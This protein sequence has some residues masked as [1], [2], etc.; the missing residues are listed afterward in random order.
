[1]LTRA[2]DHIRIELFAEQAAA[3][4]FD[5]F[6]L[7]GRDIDRIGFN[8]LRL[9]WQSVGS[10][11]CESSGSSLRSRTIAREDRSTRAHMVPCQLGRMPPF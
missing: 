2:F 8:S 5:E 9:A 7:L 6:Q 10:L 3:V 1:M 11:A 4:V